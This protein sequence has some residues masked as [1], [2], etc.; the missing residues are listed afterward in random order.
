MKIIELDE[1]DST[2]EFCKRLNV[3]EN[4]VVTAVRQT[5]GKGTNGRSFVSDEG[6]LYVSTVK[7]YKDFDFGD[8]FKIM[9]NASVA[10]CKTVESFSLRP[11]LKWAND[12]LVDGK[13][14]CG[15]LIENRLGADGTCTSIV[16]IGLNVNNVLPEELKDTATTMSESK[17]K[18]IPLAKVRSRLL[19]YLSKDYT[20]EDYKR[21]VDWFGDEVYLLRNGEQTAAKAIDVD[22]KGCLI[23]EIAGEIKKIS[24]AEMSLRLK[25]KS[26]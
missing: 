25:C 5:K 15:T 11:T 22:E 4:T 19:K 24:S 8:T 13:K 14:I 7:K 16:G 17:G 21:F 9:I 26:I 20:V 1:I 18:K 6:G 23:C 3:E 10:V 2:N 12:V